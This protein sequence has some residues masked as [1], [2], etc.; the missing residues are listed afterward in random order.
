MV[1]TNGVRR[2][3]EHSWVFGSSV[4]GLFPNQTAYVPSASAT[5]MPGESFSII[6]GDESYASGGVYRDTVK[7]GGDIITGQAIEVANASSGTFDID[8][9][10]GLAFD[11]INQGALRHLSSY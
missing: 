6:Y 10:V 2:L 7:L 8:G 5:Y 4:K 11:L 9:I 1:V 3:T